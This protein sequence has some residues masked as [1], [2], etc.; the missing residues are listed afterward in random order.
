MDTLTTADNDEFNLL[1]AFRTGD[2]VT[3]ARIVLATLAPDREPTPEEAQK[4]A[5]FAA[6]LECSEFGRA[7]ALE[8]AEIFATSASP[9]EAH[10]RLEAANAAR[11]KADIIN[12]ADHRLHPDD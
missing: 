2:R 1:T 6:Y 10:A 9:E 3:R 5:F 8:A 4:L 12:L 11:S 7:R